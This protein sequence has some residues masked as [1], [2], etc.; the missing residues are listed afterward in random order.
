M[1]Q[2]NRQQYEAEV[3]AL[4][5]ACARQLADGGTEQ[6]VA[7]WAVAQRNALKQ[8]FRASTPPADVLRLQAWTLQ[9]YGHPLG[10]TAQQLHAA[11]KSWRAIIEGAARPG[12]YRGGT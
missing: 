2:D 5:G 1:A 7:H 11:G 4:A 6:Q 12:L 3:R 9:R 10:P 8:R